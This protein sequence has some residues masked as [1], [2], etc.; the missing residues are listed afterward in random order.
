M[1]VQIKLGKVRLEEVE[2]AEDHIRP[3]C[4]SENTNLRVLEL[5]I[6]LNEINNYMTVKSMK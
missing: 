6:Q 1:L 4:H 2:K 5:G 3:D